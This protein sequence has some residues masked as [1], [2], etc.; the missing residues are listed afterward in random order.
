M[1][2]R[3][4]MFE[5]MLAA[6]PTF[7]GAWDEFLADWKNEPVDLPVYLALGDLARHIVALHMGGERQQLPAIFEV[8]ERWHLE[9]DHYVREAATIGL[10]EGLQFAA[11]H[12]DVEEFE[13]EFWLQPES[14]KWWDRLTRFWAGDPLALRGAP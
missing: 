11:S 5:P 12:T 2:D 1:I 6:C 4:G 10:L 13:F 3:Q 7:R 14:R 8:V 9:G